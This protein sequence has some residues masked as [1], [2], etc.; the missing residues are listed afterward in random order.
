[1]SILRAGYIAFP[2]SPRNSP[3][4]VAHLVNA[5]SVKHIFVGRE[6]A[7]SDLNAASLKVLESLYS[8]TSRPTFSPAPVFE[9]LFVKKS[10]DFDEIPF[11][12]KSLGDVVMYMHS[13]GQPFCFGCVITY[14]IHTPGST[15]FPKAVPWTNRYL[16]ELALHPYFGERDL[17][18]LVFSL[19][20]I[21]MY[22]GMG[23]IQL[24][25]AVRFTYY[26]RGHYRIYS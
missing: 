19:H 25:W 3:E 14:L 13:S 21:P 4:A 16:N 18:D 8:N 11:E 17:T 15:A 10:H 9:E 12:K 23:S 20:S 22:H 5:A 6:K 26:R 1:M 7:L 2:I 24:T